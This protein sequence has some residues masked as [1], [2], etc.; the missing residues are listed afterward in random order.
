M[1]WNGEN[2][3]GIPCFD[4]SLFIIKIAHLHSTSRS[5]INLFLTIVDNCIPHNIDGFLQIPS[6]N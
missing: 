2:A 1:N 3:L 6:K 4:I 5:H